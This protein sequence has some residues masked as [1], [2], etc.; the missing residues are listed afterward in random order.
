MKARFLPLLLS[1][2]SIAVS[3]GTIHYEGSSTIGKFIADADKIYPHS[4]FKINDDPESLGGEQCASLGTCDLGGVARN[5]TPDAIENGVKTN[6][7]GQ[8]AITVLVNIRNPVRSLTKQQLKA[9]F[10][11]KI[12]NWR[13]L[14]GD[15]LVIKPFIVKSASA[16][17]HVFQEKIMDGEAYIG[18]TVVSPDRKILAR[19][20]HDRG[21]IGQL[22]L[23]FLKGVKRIGLVSIDGENATFDNPH[24]P[25]SRPLYLVTPGEPNSEIK[26]FIDWAL[27]EEGQSVVRKRFVGLN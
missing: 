20:I 19:V 14:G 5:V 26:A 22:S 27:S 21:A 7:I 10:T 23:A 1:I 4:T 24:Y 17:R 11:G 25:I 3:A 18:A 16:T 9:I 12:N 15:D 13:E 6:K 2:A 8:D